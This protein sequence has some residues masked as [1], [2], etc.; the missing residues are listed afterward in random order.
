M[1]CLYMAFKPRR[2]PHPGGLH[3]LAGALVGDLLVD[4]AGAFARV[5][6]NGHQVEDVRHGTR[7]GGE[8]EDTLL[9]H[10]NLSVREL[11]VES[12]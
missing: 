5:G 4:D 7:E 12:G 8:G 2:S 11:R 1:G 3:T 9:A 10:C 6:C